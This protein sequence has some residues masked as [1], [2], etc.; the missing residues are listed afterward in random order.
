MNSYIM[1]AFFGLSSSKGSGFEDGLELMEDK[2]T[3]D[4]IN[5]RPHAAA[6][7]FG[8][9]FMT[10]VVLQRAVHSLEDRLKLSPGAKKLKCRNV[11]SNTR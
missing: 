7:I 8:S 3:F 11:F 1:S 10:L 6:F 4:A 9:V 2:L 5:T